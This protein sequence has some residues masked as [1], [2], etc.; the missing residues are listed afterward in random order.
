MF[1]T[2][3]ARSDLAVVLRCEKALSGSVGFGGLGTVC[4][5]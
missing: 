2:G 3:I 4:Y 5:G 1:R